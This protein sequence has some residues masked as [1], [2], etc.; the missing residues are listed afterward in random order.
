MTN[1]KNNHKKHWDT[2]GRTG[3]VLSNGYHHQA[4]DK[5][6]QYTHRR[7]MEQHLGR[8]LDRKEHVHHIDGNKLNN[9]ISNLTVVD[10]K[11]HLKYHAL[12]NGF[13]RQTGIPPVNKTDISTIARIKELRKAGWLLKDIQNVVGVSWVTVSKYTKG[14]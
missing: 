12:Q 4:I 5:E 14:I 7:I 8:K 10:I 6:R 13:G 1:T 11:E 9:K 2:R 3:T